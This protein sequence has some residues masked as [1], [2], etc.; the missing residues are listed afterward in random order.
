VFIAVAQRLG[1]KVHVHDK[2]YEVY[3]NIAEIREAVTDDPHCTRVHA[4][5]EYVSIII[6][7]I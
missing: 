3:K 7:L 5:Q 6:L 1:M 2:A 4:C